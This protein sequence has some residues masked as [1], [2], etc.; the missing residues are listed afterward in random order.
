MSAEE[1]P[2]TPS[3]S[4]GPD[5]MYCQEC[6][7][8]IRKRAELCPECGVRVGSSQTEDKELTSRQQTYMKVLLGVGGVFCAISLLFLPVVFAPLALL[9]GVVVALKYDTKNGQILIAAAVICGFVG[10][11]VGFLVAAYL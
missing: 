7:S 11:A 9:L 8:V 6:G 1:Q 10:A 4:A 3:D 5:E 2:E